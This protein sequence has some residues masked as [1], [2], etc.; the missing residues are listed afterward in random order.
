MTINRARPA[1]YHRSGL[2]SGAEGRVEVGGRTEAGR[3]EVGATER[4]IIL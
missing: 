1:A 4:L 2:K 3:V